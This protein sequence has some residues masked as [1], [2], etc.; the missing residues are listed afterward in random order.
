MKKY[1]YQILRYCHDI[2]TGEFV[3]VGIVVYEPASKF[4]KAS[5]LK[6]Y[7]RISKFFENVDGQFILR[8]LQNMDKAIQVRAKEIH[9]QKIKNLNQITEEILPPDDGSFFFS[10]PHAAMDLDLS[11]ALDDLFERYV[12]KHQPK[13]KN[14]NSDK[15]IWQNYYKKYFD[16]YG[17]TP[18]LSQHTID[19]P[20]DKFVFERVWKNGAIH[21]FEP[22]SFNLKE[23]NSIKDKV[24]KWDGKLNELDTNAEKLH[25]YLLSSLPEKTRLKEFIEQ[26]LTKKELKNIKLSLI[27]EDEAESFSE[28][29]RD[30][31]DNYK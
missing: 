11:L 6:K 17:I 25:L 23:E 5:M 8:V 28:S 18:V 19:T 21:V 27:K 29:L 20:T 7:A 16:A 22:L 26:K 13:E 15:L 12:N 3:N 31:I 2:V 14:Y 1:Q 24:Y 30:E 4:L 10:Q 9:N